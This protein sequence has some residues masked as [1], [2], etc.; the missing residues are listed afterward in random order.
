MQFK[1]PLLDFSTNILL[2]KSSF[3]G[4][5][6]APKESNL[7]GNLNIIHIIAYFYIK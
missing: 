3:E 1:I 7:V 4:V 5:Y 2:H 6:V